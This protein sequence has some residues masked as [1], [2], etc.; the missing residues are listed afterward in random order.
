MHKM[1]T[2]GFYDLIYWETVEDICSDAFNTEFSFDPCNIYCDGLRVVGYPADARSVG[3]SH[4]S[5]VIYRN[6]AAIFGKIM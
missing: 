4:S 3:D 1:A 5:C 2:F 6:E